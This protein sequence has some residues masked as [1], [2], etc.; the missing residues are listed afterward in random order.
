MH[1][2]TVIEHHLSVVPVH[3]QDADILSQ[4][5]HIIQANNIISV[6]H[7]VHSTILLNLIKFRYS[8]SNLSP[9]HENKF[10]YLIS[11]ELLHTITFTYVTFAAFASG[12]AFPIAVD[13]DRY[14]IYQYCFFQHTVFPSK[15]C[16]SVI[17]KYF[18]CIKSWS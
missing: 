12:R 1:I 16:K 6:L 4:K 2:L 17:F 18:I 11:K 13:Y 10:Q 7:I 15:Q 9:P 8:T 3:Q 14:I 5:L